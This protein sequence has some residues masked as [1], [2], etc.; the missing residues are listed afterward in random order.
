MWWWQWVSSPLSEWS[1][2]IFLTPYNHGENVL[3]VSLNKTVPSS[4]YC[5]TTCC[6]SNFYF[7]TYVYSLKKKCDKHIFD[8]L[9]QTSLTR[10]RG[11]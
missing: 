5:G 3:S 11:R 1:F 10:F 9:T 8:K 7:C 4:F 6:E 2:T